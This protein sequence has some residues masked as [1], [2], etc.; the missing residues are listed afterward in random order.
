MSTLLAE[1]GD[2]D[3]GTAADPCAANAARGVDALGGAGFDAGART[4]AP[5]STVI[6]GGGVAD[7]D[8]TVVDA[9]ESSLRTALAATEGDGSTFEVAGAPLL[10]KSA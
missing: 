2:D 5:A 4:G 10:R 8:A 1:E 9:S 6:E 3:E 7:V